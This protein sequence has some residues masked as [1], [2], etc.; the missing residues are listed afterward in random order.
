M[1]RNRALTVTKSRKPT[2]RR[3]VQGMTK[4]EYIEHHSAVLMALK[5]L[6]DGEVVEDELIVIKQGSEEW[7][8]KH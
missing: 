5:A 8:T 2:E 7:L 3:K 4:T 1:P 6:K